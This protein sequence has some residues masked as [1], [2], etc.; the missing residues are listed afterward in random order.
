[1]D[2]RIDEID[3][4][5]EDDGGTSKPNDLMKLANEPKRSVDGML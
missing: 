2:W 5:S 3:E 1:M 4:T